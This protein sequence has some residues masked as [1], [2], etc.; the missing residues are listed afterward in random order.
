VP[1]HQFYDAVADAVAAALRE[2]HPSV[3]EA[4]ATRRARLFI[5]GHSSAKLDADAK[6]W[7][8]WALK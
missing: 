4:Q 7:L 1:L 2:E 8:S 3:T 5:A 6:R